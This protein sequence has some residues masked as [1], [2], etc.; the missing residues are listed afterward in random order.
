RATPEMLPTLSL[1]GCALSGLHSLRSSLVR[2]ALSGLHSLRSSPDR[3]ALSGLHSLRSSLL[4][5]HLFQLCG[6]IRN[7]LSHHLHLTVSTAPYDDVHLS[8]TFDLFRIVLAK[9]TAATLLSLD[10]GASDRFR[11][12]QEIRQIECG[13]PAGVVFT[14]AVYGYLACTLP[15]RLDFLDR[16]HHFCLRSHDADKVLHRFLQIVLKAIRI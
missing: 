16:S 2:C 13:V 8:E 6:H 12:N 9:M 3:C 15:K 11:N 10:R 14:I 5:D 1:D 4:L 7:L